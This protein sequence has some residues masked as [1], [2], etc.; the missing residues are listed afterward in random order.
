MPKI[1][2]IGKKY[3]RWT[4]I[5]KATSD[6]HGKGRW[7]CR[8]ECGNEKII[9]A[10]SLKRN[11]SKSCGCYKHEVLSHGFKDISGAFWR[12]FERHAIRRKIPF[13]LTIEDGWKIFEK[14][15]GLCALSGVPICFVNNYDK[16]LNQT[17]SPDRID[18]AK[19]YTKDNVQWVHKRVNRMKSVLGNEEFLFWCKLIYLRNKD[20]SKSLKY[21][22]KGIGW[23]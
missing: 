1:D 2:L 18:N 14:Q 19:P 20:T 16:H 3:N 13:L 17:A 9:A 12:K 22:T 4:V 23:K 7:L 10:A 15:N 6:K 5:E 21:D 8:C 11:L